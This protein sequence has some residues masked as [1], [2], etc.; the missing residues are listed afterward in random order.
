MRT[1]PRLLIPGLALL[2]AACSPGVG[3]SCTSN[4]D[5]GAELICDRSQPG[6]SCT[7]TPCVRSGCPSN[8]VCVVYGDQV[9]YCMALCGP[10]SFCRTD[11]TCLEGVPRT[12]GEGEVYPAFCSPAPAPASVSRDVLPADTP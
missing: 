2:C 7:R 12:D 10:F 1:L 8:A 5:C 11:Y 4:S 9:S 3:D 6:G